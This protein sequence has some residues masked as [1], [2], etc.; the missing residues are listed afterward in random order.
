MYEQ[1]QLRK[2]LVEKTG[3]S[4]QHNGW[5]CNTCFHALD[6][7]IT[8]QRLHELWGAVLAYRGDYSPIDVEQTPDVVKSNIAEL[9]HLLDRS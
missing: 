2:T 5:P 6:L 9:K 8:P 3:C 4:I 1:L 7:G